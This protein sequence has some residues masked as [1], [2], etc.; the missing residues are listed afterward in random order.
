M[1][2]FWYQIPWLSSN[3][4][5]DKIPLFV[6]TYCFLLGFENPKLRRPPLGEI[7]TSWGQ[8]QLDSIVPCV[9]GVFSKICKACIGQIQTMGRS[10]P[11]RLGI[12]IIGK[13]S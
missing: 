13:Q 9:I 7:A 12:Y 6:C 3:L 5:Y 1:S 8:C 11:Y 2:P 10:N 4:Q